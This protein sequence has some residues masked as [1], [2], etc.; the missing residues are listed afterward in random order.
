M[1]KAKAAAARKAAPTQSELLHAQVA[2]SVPP[3]LDGAELRQLVE[4]AI[5]ED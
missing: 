1:D 3:P 4:W 5:A 2:E